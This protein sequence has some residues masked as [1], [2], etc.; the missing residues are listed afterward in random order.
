L[1]AWIALFF[2]KELIPRSW[3]FLSVVAVIYFAFTVGN[4]AYSRFFLHALPYI[5]PVAAVNMVSFYDWLRKS[6][7]N[8]ADP[9]ISR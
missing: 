6:A 4:A 2:V 9:T 1:A 8:R 5:L 7:L 3:K